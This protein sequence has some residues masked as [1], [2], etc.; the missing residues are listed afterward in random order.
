[1][2]ALFED[3]VADYDANRPSYPEPLY[4]LLIDR[5]RLDA[6][7]VIV[8]VGAGTGK[9][10]AP[11]LASGFRVIAIDAGERMLA[12]TLADE[13]SLRVVAGAP[14]LPL[15]TATADVIVCAQSFH[16]FATEETLGEFARIIRP[17]GRLALFWN[18]RR[19]EPRHQ[20]LYEEL[21]LKYNPEHDCAYRDKDWSGLIEQGGRFRML[22]R[23]SYEHSQA[24]S[25]QSWQGLARSTSYIRC[26][27]DSKLAA[28]ERELGGLMAS[29][30]GPL[31]IHYR[32]DLWLA[33]RQ[34]TG[35]DA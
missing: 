19:S 5:C 13:R 21:I 33:V 1:M 35:E 23:A 22:E 15:A 20:E 31:D 12:R 34:G 18:T 4:D 9:G 17:G 3:S 10:S 7:S 2:K 16:W 24:M 25:V 8:D 27:G 14:D 32:T 6:H 29:Q 11:L 30:P 26:I 28:F